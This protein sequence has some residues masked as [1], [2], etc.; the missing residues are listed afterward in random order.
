MKK[1]IFEKIVK[2]KEFSKL[3]KQDVER[4][5][6]KFEK[7]DVSDEE[8]IRLTRDLLRKIFSA[9]LSKKLLKIKTKNAEWFLRKH[10]S[11][12][13]RLEFYSEIYKK[14][15]K[16]FKGSVID[17]GCGVNGLSYNYFEKEM[18]Y[19]GVEAVGQLVKLVNNYFEKEKISGKVYHQSLFNLKE[20][21]KIIK[22]TKKPRIVFLFKTLDSLEMIERDFSKKLLLEISPFV[23]KIVVSFATRSLIKKTKFRANRNWI[24]NF[25]KKDFKILKEF[26]TPYEKFIV[27]EKR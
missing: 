23:N 17:L 24:L 4:V 1:E 21:L 11:T 16:N 19:I 7:R 18:N 5:F 26:E 15:L 10:I 12:K 2:K 20:I 27:F 22:K 13:E 3:P 14:L 6:K 25:I 9:F 8:K